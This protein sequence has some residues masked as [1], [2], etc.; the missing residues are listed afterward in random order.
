MIPTVQWLIVYLK[1]ER[2]HLHTCTPGH[3]RRTHPFPR[4][5]VLSPFWRVLAPADPGTQAIR[6]WEAADATSAS[7][8][9]ATNLLPAQAMPFVAPYFNRGNF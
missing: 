7:D 5:R 3:G 4:W 2:G 1:V 9:L 6:D 8:G